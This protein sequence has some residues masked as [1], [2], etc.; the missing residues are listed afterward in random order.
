MTEDRN[1]RLR[2]PG[3]LLGGLATTL[4]LPLKGLF[5]VMNRRQRQV[6]V[7]I[8]GALAV[9]NRIAPFLLSARSE[10]GNRC[11]RVNG[12]KMYM[13]PDEQAGRA[14]SF[15]MG[16]YEP[17]ATSI[18]LELVREGDVVVDVG[19][20]WGYFTLL[21]ASRCGERGR[22][23]AFEPHPKNLALLKKNI[24]ANGLK[25]VETVQKAVSHQAGSVKL[26]VSSLTGGHSLVAPPLEGSAHLEAIDVDTV[27]L[28][29]FFPA[30]RAEPRLVKMDI[31]GSE[32]LALAGMHGLIERNPRL[33]LIMEF[34]PT[35]MNVKV[36]TEFLDHLAGLGFDVAIIDDDERKLAVGPKAAV[37]KHL[38]EETT[39]CNLLASR[40][41]SL[42]ERLFAHQD[43]YGKYLGSLE[44]VEL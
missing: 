18:V 24:E 9:Y 26:F 23:F 25:N 39:T 33:A 12:L 37:L 41:H 21:A 7:R 36:A 15:L 16:Q 30:G 20:H 27:A 40:D 32:P 28:D 22:V 8:P 42:V 6:L 35:Y 10:E 13:D 17:A 38:L 4:S 3:A 5:K 14:A 19:A 43:G 1:R 29:D 34:N 31:E 44:K 2:R 11:A